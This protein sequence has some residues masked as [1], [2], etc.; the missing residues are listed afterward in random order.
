MHCHRFRCNLTKLTQKSSADWQ[1]RYLLRAAVVS[2]AYSRGILMWF[3]ASLVGNLASFLVLLCPVGLPPPLPIF[4]TACQCDRCLDTWQGGS[5]LGCRDSQPCN[6]NFVQRLSG[7]LPMVALGHLRQPTSILWLVGD[8]G[9]LTHNILFDIK[10][11]S[12]PKWL[13]CVFQ[14]F[15][16][17]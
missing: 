10:N 13:A 11:F 16:N 8:C 6:C 2:A 3:L 7:W 15:D 12:T 1:C 5:W 4:S 9:N 14:H 17:F